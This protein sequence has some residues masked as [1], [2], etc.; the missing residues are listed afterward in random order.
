MSIKIDKRIIIRT[1]LKPL[2]TDFSEHEILLLL[3]DKHI[4]EALYLASPILVS[5]IDKWI[6]SGCP[7]NKEG[8]ALLISV[9]KYIS[10]L[11]SRCTPFGLFAAIGTSKWDSKIVRVNSRLR[12]ATRLDMDFSCELSKMIAQLEFIR[13][14]LKYYPNSSL[15]N[16]GNN[17]RYVEYSYKEGKRVYSLAAVKRNK[18]LNQIIRRSQN[19]ASIDELTSILTNDNVGIDDALI[20]VNEIISCQILVNQ[21]EPAI[22]GDELVTQ[23]LKI[24]QALN[25]SYK[26]DEITNL[27]LYLESLKKQLEVIDSVIGNPAEKYQEIIESIRKLDVKYKVDRLFQTDLF[28]TYTSDPNSDSI[29]TDSTKEKIGYVL[30]VLNRL[31]EPVGSI[32]LNNFKAKFSSRYE[33]N[34]VP[35]VEALDNEWGIGY[36]A[37]DNNK[38]VNPLINDLTLPNLINSPE[39]KWTNIQKFLFKQLL[40]ANREEL[41][42]IKISL[43]DVES[44]SEDWTNIPSTISIIFNHLGKRGDSDWLSIRKVGGAS[45][46]SWLGRFASNDSEINTLVSDISAWESSFYNNFILAEIV[47]LPENRVGNILMRPII[48]DFEIVYLSNTYLQKEKQININDLYI[49]LKDNKICLRSKKHNKLVIPRLTN[50]HNFYS[51]SLP[52]YSFL[53]DLQTQDLTPSLNFDW[54]VLQDEFDFLPRVEIEDIVVSCAVWRI[55]YENFE[56]LLQSIK[57]DESTLPLVIKQWKNRLQLPDLILLVE[58]DNELLINLTNSLSQ[59]MFVGCLKNRRMIYVKEFLFD[60]SNPF[61]TDENGEAFTN[62]IILTAYNNLTSN[63]NVVIKPTEPVTVSSFSC[64]SEWLYYKIYCGVKTA[65]TILLSVIKSLI[66]RLKKRKLID[67]WFFIRY[68]DPEP[69][70]RVRLKL[71]QINNLNEIIG[72]FHAAIRKYEINR[73]VW[74]IQCDTY[75]REIGRY[76]KDAILNSEEIFFHDSECILSALSMMENYEGEEA[77]YLFALKAIDETL[78]DFNF[79]LLRRSELLFRLK[80]GYFLEHQGN[81]SLK[82]QLDNKFRNLRKDVNNIFKEAYDDNILCPLLPFLKRRSKRWKRAITEILKK[83]ENETLSVPVDNLVSSFIHMSV[84]RIFRSRQRMHELVLYDILWKYYNSEIAQGRR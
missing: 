22:T 83:E 17:I 69:H 1:P 54:G 71:K 14:L 19:G 51:N 72:L 55:K 8:N 30:S 47:H 68:K 65:D 18:Y 10:R 53:C 25:G 15:Y 38:D 34:E 41:K 31:K 42:V 6:E 20:Y 52:I 24:L 78:N 73:S 82:V 70:I 63:P 33:D 23:I 48:R 66:L 2:K 11:H 7:K 39:I 29:N 61:V 57:D 21:F 64:G 12:R 59:K 84:I 56:E 26:S 76:G 81:K 4:K 80:T 37:E 44:F 13:P 74:N 67:S 3:L 28:A 79:D 36:G 45:A 40:R 77:R 32:K 16:I 9:Y 60:G 43:K 49:S 62:E 58:G 27:K 5:E 46:A 75:K 35:L 50:A